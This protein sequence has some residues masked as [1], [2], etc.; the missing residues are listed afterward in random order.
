MISVSNAD[1][2]GQASTAAL[3][4]AAETASRK[5]HAPSEIRPSAVVVTVIVAAK[6]LGGAI[7][8]GTSEINPSKIEVALSRI[9]R[10]SGPE[11]TSYRMRVPIDPLGGFIEGP[12][13]A[14]AQRT[15]QNPPQAQ[16]D[17]HASYRDVGR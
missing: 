4:F 10:S 9:F 16:V 11:I 15:Y 2:A 17:M 8:A 1:P 12:V 7:N 6:A 13:G 14:L 5:E 3:V